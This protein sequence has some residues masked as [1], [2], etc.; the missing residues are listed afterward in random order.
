MTLNINAATLKFVIND[1]ETV[2]ISN[3]YNNFKDKQNVQYRLAISNFCRSTT[4]NTK[5]SWFLIDVC[6]NKI[7]FLLNVFADR[8]QD[9]D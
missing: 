4:A 9:L 6:K 5:L 1:T 3:I 7:W 2:K 8:I